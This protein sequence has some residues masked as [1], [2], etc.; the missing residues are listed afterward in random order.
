MLLD[1]ALAKWSRPFWC[2]KEMGIRQIII[3]WNPHLRFTLGTG[4]LNLKC[5]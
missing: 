1:P 4:I 5:G 2:L 3:Q